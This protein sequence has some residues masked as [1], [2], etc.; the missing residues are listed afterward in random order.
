M[1][2]LLLIVVLGLLF[3][4]NANAK[5][6]NLKTYAKCNYK[7]TG[8]TSILYATRQYF[9]LKKNVEYFAFDKENFYY[10]YNIG[11]KE[12]DSS[13]KIAGRN[14]ASMWSFKFSNEDQSAR[15][16]M[17]FNTVSGELE[18]REDRNL[19]G[20]LIFICDKIRKN[21]LPKSKF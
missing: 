2:K 11:N 21:Q 14:N 9:Y 15:V 6:F 19:G 13:R 5:L 16:Q 12:F 3:F 7:E 8:G 1:K 18:I 17:K 4:N 10:T 20:Y